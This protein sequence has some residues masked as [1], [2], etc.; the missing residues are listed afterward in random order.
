MSA[1]TPPHQAVTAALSFIKGAALQ[2]ASKPGFAHALRLSY[3]T[4]NADRLGWDAKRKALTYRYAFEDVVTASPT[5]GTMTAIMDELTT[6]ACFAVGQPSAPGLSLHMDMEWLID[7]P[8]T[9]FGT[10]RKELDVV[11]IV[12]KLGRT[13]SFTR[14]EYVHPVTQQIVAYGTHV[15]YMP[16][17]SFFL[18]II[19]N[20][21]WAYALYK[22]VYRVNTADV[23]NTYP[24]QDVIA[25]HMQHTGLGHA[26]FHITREHTNP[27]GGLH[28][29]CHA[30]LMEAVAMPLA[31]SVLSK[32]MKISTNGDDDNVRAF[33]KSIKI[34][35]LSAG[36]VGQ[37]IR[38]TAE[39]IEEEVHGTKVSLRVKLS[40][41]DGRVL[42]DATMLVAAG[43]SASS[44]PPVTSRM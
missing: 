19:F 9:L 28:G 43:A 14:A 10:D 7:D 4:I 37:D 13:I 34:D 44:P 25:T 20:K 1:K 41:S 38:I 22:A 26:T 12:T 27:F 31:K 17:G 40:R 8:T 35:Y 18:D 21:S 29:G 15:K 30:V 33:V 36:K 23:P 3:N 16:T 24:L 39:T 5:L 11:N 6:N 2:P 42:S 32:R